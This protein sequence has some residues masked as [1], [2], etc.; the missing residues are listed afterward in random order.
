VS[1][2]WNDIYRATFPDLVR[3]LHRK[4]WDEDRARDLAQE[5]FVRAL[6]EE[7]RKP[8]AFLFTVAANLARDEARTVVRRK[9]HLTLLRTEQEGRTAREDPEKELVHRQRQARLR[10]A[11]E[12]LGE[13]DR[14]VLLLW[15]AGLNYT[16]IAEETGLAVGSV[17]TTLARARA[18]LVEACEAEE[19]DHVARR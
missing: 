14:E 3:F 2:D 7:P 12:T 9:E 16:E 10:A 15:D 8:R 17:G 1:V 19:D 11:L 6:G 13:R 18:R 4:V 5:V